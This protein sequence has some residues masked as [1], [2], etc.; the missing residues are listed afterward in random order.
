MFI[1]R[2]INRITNGIHKSATEFHHREDQRLARVA[3]EYEFLER[4]TE[5][6]EKSARNRALRVPMPIPAPSRPTLAAA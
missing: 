3:A 6:K 1:D 2:M 5:L 4:M